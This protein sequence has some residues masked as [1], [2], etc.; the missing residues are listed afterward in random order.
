MNKK[1]KK[2]K[3]N[4]EVNLQTKINLVISILTLLASIITFINSFR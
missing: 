1:K 3:Y 4:N 2:K